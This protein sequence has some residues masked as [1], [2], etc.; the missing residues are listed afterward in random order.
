MY[1]IE[2]KLDEWQKHTIKLKKKY[3]MEMENN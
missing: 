1:E 3:I 2:K